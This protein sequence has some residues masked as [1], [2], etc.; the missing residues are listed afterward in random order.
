MDCPN[1]FPSGARYKMLT[2]MDVDKV[3]RGRVTRPVVAAMNVKDSE[4]DTSTIHPVAVVLGQ[5]HPVAYL[6][7]NASSV[8]EEEG[9]SDISM[10]GPSSLIRTEC[11]VSVAVPIAK[12]AVSIAGLI[13][14]VGVTAD[15]RLKDDVA[16]LRVP[17]LWW[18]CMITNSNGLLEEFYKIWKALIDD[19][20]HTV[21]V[22]E[23]VVKKLCRRPEKLHKPEAIEL[24]MLP[25]KKEVFLLTDYVKL[26]ISDR[27]LG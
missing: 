3:K 22:H 24:A 23:D 9:D 11:A 18:D 5:G 7:A 8:L 21:L 20:S 15:D 27:S 25:G 4:D 2:Q 1:D 6:P 10:S 12:P 16:P 17:H 19:R 26:Q 13:A 14:S